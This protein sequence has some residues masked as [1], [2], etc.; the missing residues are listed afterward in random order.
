V[1]GSELEK[2]NLKFQ[3]NGLCSGG[4]YGGQLETTY[5]RKPFIYWHST[6]SGGGPQP[7]R[8]FRKPLFN[9][10]SGFLKFRA[11]MKPLRCWSTRQQ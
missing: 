11:M 9:L 4:Q 1:T 6:M 8:E 5:R 7:P 3:K 2:W 10:I